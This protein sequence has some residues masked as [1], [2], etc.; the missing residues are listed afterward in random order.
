MVRRGRAGES[1]RPGKPKM[2]AHRLCLIAAA[3]VLAA[4]APVAETGPY[5]VW[6]SPSLELESLDQIDARLGRNLW[7]SHDEGLHMYGGTGDNPAEVDARN[8]TG[9]KQYTDA[10]YTAGGSIG[11]G[12]QFYVLAQCQAILWLNDAAPAQV[13]YLRDFVLNT[14]AVNFL[15]AMIDHSPGCDYSCRQHLANRRRIPLTKFDEVLRIGVKSDTEIEIEV[16]TSEIRLEFVA[17]GDFNGDGADDILAIT[18]A[19]ATG[20]SWRGAG[21]YLLSRDAPGVILHVADADDHLCKTYQ[22]D[23]EL[24]CPPALPTAPEPN[25]G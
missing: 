14:Y 22:C 10:G 19:S 2:I 12:L 4:C 24:D 21:L 17:R 8:C 1:R 3:A 5:P 25:G 15:P 11:I 16:L 13:S 18:Y 7:P 20:G 23:P 6:W 9:L